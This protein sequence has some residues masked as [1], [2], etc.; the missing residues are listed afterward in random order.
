MRRRLAWRHR[1]QQCHARPGGQATACSLARSQQRLRSAVGMLT[2][3]SICGDVSS[4]DSSSEMKELLETVFRTLARSVVFC[5]EAELSPD[6][7]QPAGCRSLGQERYPIVSLGYSAAGRRK[8]QRRPAL[9]FEPRASRFTPLGR[10]TAAPSFVR[11]S[12]VWGCGGVGALA[13]RTELQLG[14]A[15]SRRSLYCLQSFGNCFAF[16]L[17]QSPATRR[18]LSQPCCSRVWTAACGLLEMLC[19]LSMP[20]DLSRAKILSFNA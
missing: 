14:I 5:S 17:A 7:R 11:K 16:F 18:S 10:T 3:G 1:S 4:S 12:A 6:F 15:S 8:G 2:A 20:N 13:A 9:R 19:G